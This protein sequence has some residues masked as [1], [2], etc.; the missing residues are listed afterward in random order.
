MDVI[1]SGALIAGVL[2]GYVMF[3]VL[4]VWRLRADGCTPFS[5]SPS[6]TFDGCLL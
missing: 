4:L 1:D 3:E 6:D 2:D 5:F